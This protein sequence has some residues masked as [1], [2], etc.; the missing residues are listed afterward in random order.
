[1]ETSDFVKLKADERVSVLRKLMKGH[2]VPRGIMGHVLIKDRSP[3]VKGLL[4]APLRALV[5]VGMK[6]EPSSDTDYD[7]LNIGYT[8][9]VLDALRSVH[10]LTSAKLFTEDFSRS[11]SYWGWRT[12][13]YL[14]PSS[15]LDMICAVIDDA[16]GANIKIGGV[17]SLPLYVNSRWFLDQLSF[18]S[19][20]DLPLL[21][22]VTEKFDFVPFVKRFYMARLKGYPS[23]YLSYMREIASQEKS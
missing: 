22:H 9:P 3:R 11:T 23:N 4:L 8:A 18:C 6:D 14:C 16:D 19:D 13:L 10:P 5:S 7:W 2:S 20:T 1:M 17:H 15:H 12:I 21:L